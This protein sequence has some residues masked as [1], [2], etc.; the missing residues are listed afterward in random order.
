M[1]PLT[2]LTL[3]VGAY[4]AHRYFTGTPLTPRQL[5]ERW[6]ETLVNQTPED[7]IRLYAQTGV[8]IPTFGEIKEGREAMREYFER[9]MSYPQLRGAYDTMIVQEYISN[10]VNG[11]IVSGAYT[12][13]FLLEGVPTTV[14]ARYSFVFNSTGQILNHHSSALPE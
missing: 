1:H 12:F 7:M 11:C 8:L 9:F 5:A 14:K 2:L 10:R 3:G 4:G 13:E 6:M